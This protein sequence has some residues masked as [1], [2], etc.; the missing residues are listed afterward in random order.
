[1]GL[2]TAATAGLMTFLV[3]LVWSPIGSCHPMA[4][5][6]QHRVVLMERLSSPGFR[7]GWGNVT[8]RVCK[9]VFGVIDLALAV[10]LCLFACF[11]LMRTNDN[12]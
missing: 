12:N 3:L 6:E 5:A 4:S 9:I 1:M 10:M 8:C 11:F 2:R 7:F